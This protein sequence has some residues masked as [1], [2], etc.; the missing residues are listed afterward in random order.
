MGLAEVFGLD[1]DRIGADQADRPH[2]QDHRA[3]L[4]E[5][6]PREG[7]V[8]PRVRIPVTIERA[9]PSRG[10]RLIHRR[11]MVDP[12][13]PRRDPA[14]KGRQTV[15]EARLNER[16]MRRTTPVMDESHDWPNSQ[17]PQPPESGIGPRPVGGLGGVAFPEHRVANRP[18]S[19]RGE[20]VEILGTRIVARQRHLVEITVA[21]SID[22]AFQPRPDFGA[23]HRLREVHQFLRINRP[24]ADLN[25]S[26][27]I[28][29]LMTR[30]I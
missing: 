10:Q 5:E 25:I 28:R 18:H 22:R 21:N 3:T 17:R 6:R 23:G 24:G 14:G 29:K 16:R 12:G 4:V 20:A 8:F 2:A 1:Q 27:R 30:L 15:R 7:N 19:Q 11:V 26:C 13:I 9:E